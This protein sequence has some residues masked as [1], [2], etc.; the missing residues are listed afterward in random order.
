M[1][2]AKPAPDPSALKRT[3][4][5]RYETG[6][7][8]FTVE[9]ES[10]GSWVL[11]DSEQTNELGLPLVRG[12]F[13]TLAAAKA[14][15]AAA[16]DAPASPSPLAERLKERAGSK[17]AQSSRAHRMERAR[18]PKARKEV[19]PPLAARAARPADA[20]AIVRIYNAGIE[21]REATFETEPR[22]RGDVL[23]WLDG[24]HP[25]VVVTRGE[26]VLAFAATFEYRPRAAYAG[27]AEF[28][29]YADPDHRREGAGRLAMESLIEAATEAGFWK[30]VSRVFPENESSR[31]LL[32][33]VGF[34]EVG[35]Y[36]RH[37]RLDGE[38]R[39][40]VIVERL[41]GEALGD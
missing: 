11:V 14:A 25:V 33:A 34:R 16:R 5:G 26:D 38:W 12:P 27:V 4:A 1:P 23:G 36:R 2:K 31:A 10:A 7:G 32:R 20:A 41:L 8:R 29:V 3:A 18:P 9:Q 13:A 17:P 19:P 6:D 40:C 24:R 39:D 15:V 35:T 22:S 28:S 30:L 21:S 37:A